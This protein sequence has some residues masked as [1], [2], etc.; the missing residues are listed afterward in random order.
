MYYSISSIQLFYY[1]I[2][3]STKIKQGEKDLAI[4]V[5]TT[6]CKDG[7]VA[8]FLSDGP[9]LSSFTMTQHLFSATTAWSSF[10]MTHSQTHILCCHIRIHGHTA[11]IQPTVLDPATNINL[12]AA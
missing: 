3:K 10:I 6:A 11:V 12:A 9:V 5:I 1:S 2:T 7:L 4:M 8:A